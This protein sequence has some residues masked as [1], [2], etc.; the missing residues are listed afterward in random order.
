[1]T[2]PLILISP[3]DLSALVT[4]AVQ[5]ATKPLEA[6]VAALRESMMIDDT[7][8]AR[9]AMK[10]LGCKTRKTL[11]RLNGRYQLG[12][13]QKGRDILFSRSRLLAWRK[14]GD[15]AHI[16]AQLTMVRR[17]RPKNADVGRIAVV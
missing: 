2:T 4:N 14:T 9:E 1:M 10:I 15:G 12:G 11:D 17:G 3:A 16:V 5:A 8:R 6:E 7:V 13:V